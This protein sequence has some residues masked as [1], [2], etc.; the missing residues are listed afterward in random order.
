VAASKSKAYPFQWAD[1]SWHS[2][3]QTTGPSKGVERP[4]PL[5]PPPVGTY[6]PSIDYNAGASQRGYDQFAGDAQTSFEQ[7]QQDYG[8]SR[9]DIQTQ[10]DRANQDYWTR[11]HDLERQYGILGHQ[12]AD[13][14]AQQGIT[15]EGLL[16]KSQAIR[17]ANQSHD[18]TGIDVANTRAA[19]DLDRAQTGL[20]LGNARQF[21]GF[22]GQTILNPLTGQPEFGSLLTSL[23]RA[24]GENNAFQTASA[25]QRVAGAQAN[26]YIAPAPVAPSAKSAQSRFDAFRKKQLARINH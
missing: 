18:Q 3:P 26:G 1:G 10:R 5:P 4:S 9:G 23:T 15:S 16:G 2:K 20:D 25:G 19:V 6:D 21:G 13:R 14:A 8:L 17:A 12:Q 7:G 22:N 24:G 11:T